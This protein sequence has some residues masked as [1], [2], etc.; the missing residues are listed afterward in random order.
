[1]IILQICAYSVQFMFLNT[2]IALEGKLWLVMNLCTGG[3]LTTRKLKEPEVT[4]VTEQILRGVAYLHSRGVCHRDLKLENI[5]YEHGGADSN[6]RLIDF[7]LSATYDHSD[8]RAKTHGAAYT[9]SPEVASKSGPYTEKSDVWAIGVII[10]VML[11]GDY[12]FIKTYEDLNNEKRKSDLVNARY[13]FGIT[14]K[15]RGITN[16]AKNFVKG[17][18]CKSPADRWT[19]KEALTYL[20]DKWIPSLEEKAAKASKEQGND[21]KD[22]GKKKRSNADIK[23]NDMLVI[24]NKTIASKA[25]NPQAFFDNAVLNSIE[26]FTEYGPLK[27]TILITCANTVDRGDLKKLRELFLL[28]NTTVTGTISMMELK[29][30]IHNLRPD[31]SDSYIANIFAALD[32]DESGQI[33]YNEFVAAV[34]EKDGLLTE[35]RL[36]DAFDRIDSEGNGF[37]TH[38]DLERILGQNYEKNFVDKMILE[39]DFKKNGRIDFEEFSQLM[40]G[41]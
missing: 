2:S 31:V 36:A 29:A 21:S 30:V 22:D 32:N 20:T 28:V 35:D 38:S 25:R 6:I 16:D 8:S 24:L 19:A 27:K 3:N 10:W 5:L 33:H 15:G 26:R 34:L 37:I 41:E 11:A 13:S 1:M 14:W 9:M 39:G 4:V 40:Q 18:L 17:C 23:M 12:P 7:G